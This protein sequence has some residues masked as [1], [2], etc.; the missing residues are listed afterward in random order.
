[1]LYGESEGKNGKGLLVSSAQ[2]TT[3]LHSLGQQIQDGLRIIFETVIE[4]KKTDSLTIPFDQD[5]LDKL[6]YIAGK[7]IS[8]VNEKALLGTQMAHVE[9]NVPN[10]LISIDKLDSYHF[11]YMIY[12]FEI[13]CAMSAYL[14]DVNPFDQ[15][16]VEAYKKN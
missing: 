8:Y 1:Q 12:F 5:D 3:D 15:P 11:G 2:F 6:N 9:G 13:A 4:L 7:E 14:L 10:I 16:G